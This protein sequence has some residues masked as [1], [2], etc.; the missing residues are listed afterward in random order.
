MMVGWEVKEIM[1][2]MCCFIGNDAVE[3]V[4]VMV[5]VGGEEAC[6]GRGD[7]EKGV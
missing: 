6:R 4:E 2:K 3:V 5:E 1:K 7:R